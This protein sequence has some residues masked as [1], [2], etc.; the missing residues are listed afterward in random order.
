MLQ[1]G[2]K[3]CQHFGRRGFRAVNV[4]GRQILALPCADGSDAALAALLLV[5]EALPGLIDIDGPA[6]GRL[7]I[8]KR[9]DCVSGNL[10]FRDGPDFRRHGQLGE[11]LAVDI[12]DILKPALGSRTALLFGNSAD[13]LAGLSENILGGL[14]LEPVRLC[15]QLLPVGTHLPAKNAQRQKPGELFAFPD[16]IVASA[17]GPVYVLFGFSLRGKKA[18]LLLKRNCRAAILDGIDNLLLQV[19][20]L[21]ID[22]FPARA[23]YGSRGR[24]GARRTRSGRRRWS[25]ASKSIGLAQGPGQIVSGLAQTVRERF[26]RIKTL[27]ECIVEQADGFCGREHEISL[28]LVLSGSM[29]SGVSLMKEDIV[30]P[31]D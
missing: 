28:M 9:V 1:Q 20:D 29:P 15:G 24:E 8:G 6:L 18:Y 21:L 10:D 26:F 7:Q 13:F 19:P 23:R 31:E 5:A 14:L 22:I 12:A 17:P 30:I 4:H 11:S 2:D 3:L 16:G 27:C 25:V